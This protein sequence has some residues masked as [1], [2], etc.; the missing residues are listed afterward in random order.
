LYLII[1]YSNASELID[2]FWRKKGKEKKLARASIGTPKKPSIKGRK[3]LP[4]DNSS[5]IDSISGAKRARKWK[6]MKEDSD[7]EMDYDEAP[8][9]K[10]SRKSNG[11]K[12]SSVTEYFGDQVL[13]DENKPIGNMKKWMAT[14]S[15][16]HIIDT[17]DTVER[18]E[19]GSL[20]VYF[21][22]CVFLCCS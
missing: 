6:S 15:W 22:L 20:L 14:K 3:S 9:K 5:E 16:E 4:K 19:D 2:E 17:I 13:D 18:A 8:V 7:I 10:K 1:L 21:T 12:N 11:T